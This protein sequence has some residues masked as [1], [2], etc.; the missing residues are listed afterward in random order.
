M[1][2]FALDRWIAGVTVRGFWRKNPKAI[3][4]RI[5][6]FEATEDDSAWQLLHAAAALPEP[7]VKAQL[8]LQSMEETHHAEIFRALYKQ[9]A[10]RPVPK[11]SVERRPLL[12]K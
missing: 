11:I 9:S 6:S 12:N 3:L 1:F 4:A 7:H 10:G 5:Q 2:T 8:F